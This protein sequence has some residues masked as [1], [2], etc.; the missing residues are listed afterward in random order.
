MTQ[1]GVRDLKTHASKI[2]EEVEERRSRYVIT[3]RGRPIGVLLP[4]EDSPVKEAAA[5]SAWEELEA[6][7]EQ[8]SRNWSSEKTTLEILDEIRR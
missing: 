8:I 5:A 1:V 4:L 7:G 6:L 3:K 2:L